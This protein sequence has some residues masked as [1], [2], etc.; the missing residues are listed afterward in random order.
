MRFLNLTLDIKQINE[1]YKEKRCPQ[2]MAPRNRPITPK[3]TG[4]PTFLKPHDPLPPAAI[5]AWLKRQTIKYLNLTVDT[6]Q[7]N[8]NYREKRSPRPMAPRNRPETPLSTGSPTFLKPHDPLPLA[9]IY[10]WLKRQ[11]QPIEKINDHAIV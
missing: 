11:R 6:R 4:S 5:S 9:A 7:I 10:A 3:P 8:E 1:N 2:P